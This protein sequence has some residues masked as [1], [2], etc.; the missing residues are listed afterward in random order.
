MLT[1]KNLTIQF[2]QKMILDNAEFYAKD[3]TMTVIK[4]KSGIGK[5]TF[6]KSLMFEYDCRYE[7]NSIDLMKLNQEE[8]QQFIYDHISFVHQ[9]PLFLSAMN[10]LSHITLYEKMG[11]RRIPELEK[12]L[13]ID[14]L[15]NKFP[16][17]LSGGE[18]TRVAIYLALLKQPDILILDE[19]TAALDDKN[20][21]RVIDLLLNYAHQ[22]HIVIISS[23]DQR[24][25]DAG[26]VICTIEDYKIVFEDDN[27][28]DPD[29]KT[30]VM[31]QKNRNIRF[32]LK[33]GHHIFQIVMNI[34]VAL[35]LIMSIY[36]MKLIDQYD[37]TQQDIVNSV[38]SLDLLVYKSKYDNDYFS[39]DGMEYPFTQKDEDLLKKID[40]VKS[41]TWTSHLDGF[42]NLMPFDELIDMDE[43]DIKKVGLSINGQVIYTDKEL[44]F[45][46][47][48]SFN[49]ENDYSEMLEIDFHQTGIYVSHGLFKR[50]IKNTDY[51][52]HDQLTLTF[53][54]FIPRYDASN[55]NGFS[56]EN[57]KYIETNRVNSV[58]KKVELPIA[59]VI[60]ED[61]VFYNLE[62]E[63]QRS[64]FIP[65]SILE[66]YIS[67]YQEMQDRTLISVY[68]NDAD[69][70]YINS[71][72][73]GVKEEEIIQK[74]AEVPWHPS[75]YVVTVDS[76]ADLEKVAEEI[77][78]LG[79]AVENQYVDSDAYEILN[80]NNRSV[81]VGF[82]VSLFIIL[83]GFY[84]YLK[85]LVINDENES[86]QY[87]RNIGLKSKN[88]NM[89]FYRNY[90]KNSLILFLITSLMF[91]FFIELFAR[92]QVISLIM[93]PKTIFFVLFFVTSLVIECLIPF[94]L[95]KKIYRY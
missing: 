90:F 89:I 28:A 64:V 6:L 25:I 58:V 13:H 49:D 23:H 37:Q 80:K 85:Y 40:N 75:S 11:K 86:R 82:I 46:H 29:S 26:D 2:D 51:D 55:I 71:I 59:G 5:S 87:L 47:Y 56:I 93:P 39:Y 8:R 69:Q 53:A 24:L 38:S 73:D 57:H 74:V 32:N 83:Y 60:K 67:Q 9:L 35:S 91:R 95:N 81:L 72:P 50:I 17:Q 78:G 30:A 62:Y 52:D 79:F 84:F 76:L 20:A 31:T 34:L 42:S 12:Q 94:V 66:K 21:R 45:L 15:L 4:G 10:I 63:S 77:K 18:K 65:N 3:N 16:K 33:T 1:V 41:I 48:N 22:G 44:D 54:L 27:I 43:E 19:P 7:Y 14:H 68:R 70:W 92:M 88:I 36:V 61:E